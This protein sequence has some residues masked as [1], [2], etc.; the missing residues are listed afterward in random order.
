MLKEP[1]NLREEYRLI[2]LGN[3]IFGPKRETVA[4]GWRNLHSNELHFLYLFP[5]IRVINAWKHEK[6]MTKF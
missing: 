3:R 1:S 5:N 2:A 4:G 6:R